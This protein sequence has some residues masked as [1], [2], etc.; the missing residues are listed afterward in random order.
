MYVTTLAISL[1]S[2][3][4]VWQYSGKI[5][6]PDSRQMQSSSVLLYKC[7]IYLKFLRGQGPR[8][9]SKEALQKIV[10]VTF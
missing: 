3:I 6:T 1:N 9:I 10:F 8:I 7:F 5:C 2:G 4:S